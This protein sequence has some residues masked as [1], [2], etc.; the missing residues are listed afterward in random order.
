MPFFY[1]VEKMFKGKFVRDKLMGR[2]LFPENDKVMLPILAQT[3]IW[4][5][6]EVRWLSLNVKPGDICLNIGA[7]VGYFS[8][9]MSILTGELGKVIAVEPNKSLRDF[10]RINLFLHKIGPVEYISAAAG[11]RNGSTYFYSN[12]QNY[13][14]GRTFNPQILNEDSN[15]NL[16]FE[17]IDNPNLVKMITIDSINTKGKRLDVILIDAQGLDIDILFGGE[18]RI[19]RD[20]PRILFEFTPKWLVARGINPIE[21]L[22]VLKN[23]GYSLHSPELHQKEYEPEEIVDEIQ[24]RNLLFINIELRPLLQR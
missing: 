18:T 6:S 11:D 7:N 9:L 23:W 24:V 2:F 3:A 1:V 21:A 13:G 22:T 15:E 19:K 14:D 4:E 16:G 20:R 17:E 5:E 12:T 8:S 10:F